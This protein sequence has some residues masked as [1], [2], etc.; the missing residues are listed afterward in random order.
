[1]ALIVFGLLFDL[2]IAVSRAGLL[3]ALAPTSGYTMPNLLILVGI[4]TYG[5]VHLRLEPGRTRSLSVR[6]LVFAAIVFLSVQLVVT[7][8][9]G[10]VGSRAFDQRL[11]VGARLVVN[12]ND[13][14]VRA[15]GCYDLYGVLYY[16]IFYPGV[17]SRYVGFTDA[18]EAH[19]TVFSPGLFQKYRAEG[20]PDIPQCRAR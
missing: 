3:S 11:V 17:S 4:V 15:Q 16:L 14:P 13:I 6:V 12:L 9:S 10:I 2:P 7:T 20:L 8:Y 5:W 18:R 1:V 19:L